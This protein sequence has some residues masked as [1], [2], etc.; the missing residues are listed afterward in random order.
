MGSWGS[1]KVKR[2]EYSQSP[3]LAAYPRIFKR[4]GFCFDA[5]VRSLLSKLSMRG[6][7]FT[8][9]AHLAKSDLH[10]LCLLEQGLAFMNKMSGHLTR[11]AELLPLQ[12]PGTSMCRPEHAC[13]A[14]PSKSFSHSENIDRGG[15]PCPT[16]VAQQAR[17][18]MLQPSNCV[19][20][21]GGSYSL[22]RL[23]FGLRNSPQRWSCK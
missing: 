18:R 21:L 3:Q 1:K 19:S 17:V 9:Q 8:T 7:T 15:R 10:V 23:R 14:V 16:R 6:P 12:V 20:S 4:L 22:C 11:N 13:W 2:L 5:I